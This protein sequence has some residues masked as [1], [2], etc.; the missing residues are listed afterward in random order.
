MIL[1]PHMNL[2]SEYMLLTQRLLCSNFCFVFFVFLGSLVNKILNDYYR[3]IK[4][5][6]SQ[7]CYLVG[8]KEK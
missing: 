5:N 3:K 6:I 7:L 2:K 8:G 1:K 4:K